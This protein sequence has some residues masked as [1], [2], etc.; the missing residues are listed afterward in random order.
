MR[1]ITD[2]EEIKKWGMQREEEAGPPAAGTGSPREDRRATGGR[3]RVSAAVGL[4]L[5]R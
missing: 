3:G 4:Q 1:N 5:G 2:W